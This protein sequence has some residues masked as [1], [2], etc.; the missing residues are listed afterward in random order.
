[1]EEAFRAWKKFAQTKEAA[2]VIRF[3]LTGDGSSAA[4]ADVSS[5]PGFA[6][7]RYD[8]EPNKVARVRNRWI[9]GVAQDV[10]VIIGKRYPTNKEVE[11]LGINAELYDG[12]WNT[13]QFISY[14]LPAHGPTHHAVYGIDPA[15][16]DIRNILNGKVIPTDPASLGVTVEPLA[17]MAYGERRFY[18]GGGVA[19]TGDV[20]GTTGY[21][22]YALVT[23]NTV[24]GRLRKIL[25][26]SNPVAMAPTPPDTPIWNIPLGLVLLYNG[27][28]EVVETNI[29]EYRVAFQPVGLHQIERDLMRYMEHQEMLWALHLSG[30]I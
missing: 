11:I 4:T 15:E 6:W 2:Q 9:P 22:R 14:L 12:A 3:A 16:L 21:Q 25:G 13:D 27:Q 19:F 17:Y 20:P 1:M 10:A 29:Y 30:D 18:G 5:R 8:E 7:V 23:L 28:T 26:V 24:E